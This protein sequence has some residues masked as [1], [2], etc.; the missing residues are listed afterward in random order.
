MD[1]VWVAS[2]GRFHDLETGRFISGDTVREYL[3]RSIEGTQNALGGMTDLIDVGTLRPAD[4][5]EA[6]RQEVKGEYIRQYLIG[7]GGLEQM[8]QSDWGSIGGMLKDQYRYLRGFEEEMADLSAAQIR[9][10]ANM[11]INSA[12]ESFER[13]NARAMKAVNKTEELWVLGEAEHCEDC[14]ALA[15]MG[16]VPIGAHGT[17]PGAGETACLTNCQCHLEYRG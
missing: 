11:Y 7:K 9:A 12:R 6:L 15:A 3:Q 1:P 17:Y 14:V 2:S 10:R 8:T 13:A 4:F 16:W 5:A